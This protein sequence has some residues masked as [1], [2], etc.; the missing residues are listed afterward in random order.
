MRSL[1]TSLF[2]LSLVCS[3]NVTATLQNPHPFPSKGPWFEGW[4]TRFVDFSN[5]RSFAVINALMLN[6]EQSNVG[7]LAILHADND[8]SKPMEVF[9]SFPSDPTITDCNLN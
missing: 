2:I 1:L 9:E 7:Y 4:Y 6:N 5:G 3:H 8:T